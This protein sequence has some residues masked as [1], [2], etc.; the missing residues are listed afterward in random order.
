MR[1]SDRRD[2]A[3]TTSLPAKETLTSD[4]LPVNVDAVLLW[5]LYDP[6]RAALEAQDD[7]NADHRGGVDGAGW[8]A[9]RGSDASGEVG[10][11][12]ISTSVSLYMQLPLPPD[13]IND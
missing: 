11:G 8:V 3:P 10:P 9:R 1:P 12:M 4:T 6:Q 5:V 7:A 13:V 2:I